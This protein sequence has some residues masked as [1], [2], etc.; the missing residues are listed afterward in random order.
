MI[1]WRGGVELR[2]I[3]FGMVLGEDGKKFSTRKGDVV[4]L[5]D[6]MKNA[7]NMSRKVV[8]KKNPSLSAKQKKKI[9]RAVG[10]G[11]IKYNDLSQNRLTDI[12]F[13]WDKMLSFEGNS[14]PYLQY[15]YARIN[16]LE[17]KFNGLY[18]LNRFNIFDKPELDLLNENAEKNIMRH[19]VKF[20][21]A[22]ENAAEENF[23]HLVALYLYELA[24]LYNNFY[25]SVP[26]LK[27]EKKL[28]KARVALSESV[29]IVIKNG[30]G[31]LGIDVLERI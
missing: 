24:S 26:I 30:L 19:L 4:L 16:S 15:V 27:S 6:L 10:I 8:E 20:P 29:A 3:K 22:I 9:S 28:A 25:N 21:E 11:A 17:E 12:T 7:I 31:L 5:D 13:N 14:G 18:R 2:H 1:G 23:P